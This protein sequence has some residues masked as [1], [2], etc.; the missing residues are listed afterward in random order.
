VVVCAL[1]LQGCAT[2]GIE[3]CGFGAT[4]CRGSTLQVCKTGLGWSDAANCEDVGSA[5]GG[6][7][8][9]GAPKGVCAELHQC[10]PVPDRSEPP[11][12]APAPK[13]EKLEKRPR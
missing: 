6:T 4:R 3:T 12:A 10:M 11:A 13:N 8:T 1:A 2:F 9:C 7:W 5:E